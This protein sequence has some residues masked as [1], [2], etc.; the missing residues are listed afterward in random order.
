MRALVFFF[1]ETERML[2]IMSEKE[3]PSNKGCWDV[4]I[5]QAV[6]P[7]LFLKQTIK[8]GRFP[9]YAALDDNEP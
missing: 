6:F 5:F 4:R 3:V 1:S 9:R 2:E 8:S 7:F